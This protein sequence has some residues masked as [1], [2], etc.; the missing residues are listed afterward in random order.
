LSG[1]MFY[2]VGE[3]SD[4]KLGKPYTGITITASWRNL[5]DRV[6][7]DLLS[8]ISGSVIDVPGIDERRDDLTTLILTIQSAP[9]AEHKKQIDAIRLD[10]D[11][12]RTYWHHR[13]DTIG[14]LDGTSLQ[15]LLKTDWAR[16]G[17]LRGLTTAL[18][19]IVVGGEPSEYVVETM[20]SISDPDLP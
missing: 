6:R 2:R 12:D 1:G 15:L 3:E 20:P 17:N 18:E 16:L 8:R 7:P 9:L 10:A 11:V 19:R 4:P 5:A 14:P 13:R